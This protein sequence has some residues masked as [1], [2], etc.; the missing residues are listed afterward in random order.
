LLDD[1]PDGLDVVVDVGPEPAPAV[2]DPEVALLLSRADLGPHARL[3]AR[4]AVDPPVALHL[5]EERLER[6]EIALEAVLDVGQEFRCT[7]PERVRV[8][9]VAPP[10]FGPALGKRLVAD[11]LGHGLEFVAPRL[12][13]EVVVGEV[14][15]NL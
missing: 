8:V 6:R 3:G 13:D 12:E 2:A 5:L 1:V 11:S 10:E 7:V 15:L 9:D 4:L 14:A